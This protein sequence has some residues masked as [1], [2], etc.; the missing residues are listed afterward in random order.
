M[1]SLQVVSKTYH[2]AHNNM[3]RKIRRRLED[4]PRIF[5]LL[6]KHH[7]Y[8]QK[9]RPSLIDMRGLCFQ[10][11]KIILAYNPVAVII[12]RFHAFQS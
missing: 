4:R 1:N 2:F 3:I 10:K 8:K 6:D 5:E 12:V 11:G 7:H 9:P